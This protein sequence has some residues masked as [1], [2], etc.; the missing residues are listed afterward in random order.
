VKDFIDVSGNFTVRSGGDTV[1]SI[2]G[3]DV[4]GVIGNL[5]FSNNRYGTNTA[6]L[7][8]DALQ[9][10]QF[11]HNSTNGD[12]TMTD[13]SYG[14]VMAFTTRGLYELT[15]VANAD[16]LLRDRYDNAIHGLRFYSKN[17]PRQRVDWTNGC[18][19]LHQSEYIL[20]RY[21]TYFGYQVHRTGGTTTNAVDKMKVGN[22]NLNNF[23]LYAINN[24]M[25]RGT[26]TGVRYYTSS[27]RRIKTNIQT[28]NDA[29]ALEKLRLL[30][31]CTYKYIDHIERGEHEVEGFI[32]QEV[33]EVMPYAVSEGDKMIPNIYQFGSYEVDASG[34]QIITIPDYDTA[35]LEVDASG[36]IF[37]SLVIHNDPHEIKPHLNKTKSRSLEVNVEIVKV[38]SSTSIQI[39]SSDRITKRIFAYGQNVNNFCALKKDQIFSVATAALQEL[40]RQL[41][42]EKLKKA[43]LETQ[44]ADLRARVNV[45]KGQ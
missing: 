8:T 33:K 40:D 7:T 21:A 35:N 20:S 24:I 17:E 15:P 14:T 32:A 29:S 4:S 42:A 41:Q 43:T 23:S 36:N 44:V 28:I 27:D 18:F 6:S 2:G 9:S 3:S 11:S 1:M 19:I 16:N 37:T 26:I 5:S 34:N 30:N 31:P 25:A 22:V 10:L 38:V 39:K 13:N 12:F 45:L